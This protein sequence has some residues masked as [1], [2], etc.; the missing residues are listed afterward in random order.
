MTDN[1]FIWDSCW[2]DAN[3]ATFAVETNTPYGIINDGVIAIRDK[4]IAWIGKRS[5]LPHAPEKLAAQ[6]YSA[7]GAWITPGFIDCH[8][9]LVY[10]G[11]RA[12]EFEQ[13]LHGTSYEQ[14][15]RAGGGILSTVAATRAATTKL[16][17]AQTLPRL[18]ALLA[19]GVTTV[20]IKSGYGLDTANEIKM[21]RVARELGEKFPVTVRTTFLGA[22]TL[23]PE[24]QQRADAYI[25]LICNEMLPTIA[26]EKLADAV[27]VFC[28]RIAF[29]PQQTEKVFQHAQQLS[30]P[31]KIHAEQLSD[32][33]GAQLAARYH[34]LSADHLEHLTEPGVQ[35]LATAGTTA[36]LLPGAY[37]FLRETKL[38]PLDLLRHYQVP[39]ALATDCNPGTSPITSLLLILNMACTLFR[40]TPEE[41]LLGITRH[42]AQ[43]LG[44]S[45]SHGT[46]SP[47]KVADFVLWDI[48]HPVELVYQIGLNPRL[49]TIKAGEKL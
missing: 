2:L 15:A 42:A 38:P 36:V 7:N 21:L 30:L 32:C 18:K 35:A 14:I 29:T 45:N 43:A 23:P 12:H 22:H 31:I 25:D 41:A 49:A 9:H 17:F 3:L 10:A 20:E 5:E 13:R 46:L 48:Q 26:A 33:G 11:N 6:V 39:I 19:E 40:L 8:T 44:L 47:G 34:A 24:Y 28:E 27:D 4:K 37:Y 16:L 1:N